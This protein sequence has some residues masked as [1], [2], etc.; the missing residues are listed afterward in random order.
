MSAT[1]GINA[2][3]MKYYNVRNVASE[4]GENGHTTRIL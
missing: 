3:D 4:H 1:I 2:V